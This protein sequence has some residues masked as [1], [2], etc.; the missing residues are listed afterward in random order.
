M[1]RGAGRHRHP[2]FRLI[3]GGVVGA[4]WTPGD[5]GGF[6]RAL[7]DVGLRDLGEERARLADH[8]AHELSWQAVGRRAVEIYE[9]VVNRRDRML[10]T[11]ENG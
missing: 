1:R 5:A 4:L 8:F 10:R 9:E 7:V 11:R 2:T 3:T 6:S